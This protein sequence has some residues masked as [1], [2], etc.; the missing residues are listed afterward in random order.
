MLNQVKSVF[1][2]ENKHVFNPQANR[3]IISNVRSDMTADGIVDDV[4]G[5]MSRDEGFSLEHIECID[6]FLVVGKDGRIARVRA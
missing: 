3:V 2:G 5:L 6:E 1:Y 4:H